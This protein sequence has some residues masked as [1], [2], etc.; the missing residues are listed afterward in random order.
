MAAVLL[1]NHL[2]CVYSVLD[3]LAVRLSPLL[4]EALLVGSG[5]TL[6]FSFLTARIRPHFDLLGV[7][8]RLRKAV[9]RRA[10]E[11]RPTAKS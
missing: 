11:I 9:V 7:L 4:L 3:F 5:W 10:L 6:P 2:F 1:R 8:L